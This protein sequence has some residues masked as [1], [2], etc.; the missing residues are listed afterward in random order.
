MI[1]QLDPDA[2][3]AGPLGQ[4]LSEQDA[5]RAKAR[6]RAAWWMRAGI[7]AACA[8]AVVVI[9]FGGHI[10]TAL[11]LGFFTG[12]G[13][14]GIG[15]LIK[16]PVI[17][18]IKTGINDAIA[19]ALG[20]HY[21]LTV[22]PGPAFQTARDFQML[23]G[24]D[25]AHFEDLWWGEVGAQQFTLHEAKLTEERGSG[26]SRRTVTVFEGSLLMIGFARRFNGA[27]LIEKD[28]QR[29][30][31]LFGSEKE[32][33]TVSGL[34][35][36]RVDMVDPA[37]EERF[38]VWSND[39]V[40]ARYLVHPEYVE[41]LTALETAFGGDN[42]RALFK[43]GSLLVVLENGN[44]FESGSLDSA[45]DR[46]RVATSIAQFGALAELATRLNEKPRAG[47]S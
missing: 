15:E 31:F 34:R 33:I 22:E 29:R 36:D 47:F 13:G 20:L 17:N 19:R 38:T 25:N 24:H 14:F 7:A 3:M 28:K 43:D 2:L 5:I 12:V 8:V 41:R 39:Q 44:Q 10:A 40:E 6:E 30:N 45:D 16:R 9:L 35:L 26:K 27:T 32:S 42:M 46:D 37:F 21:S 11:Q 23:P 4:W 1:A 18:Q